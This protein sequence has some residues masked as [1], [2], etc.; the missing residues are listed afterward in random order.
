MWQFFEYLYH[1]SKKCERHQ[2]TTLQI[3]A[4]QCYTA[5]PHQ[6]VAHSVPNYPYRKCIYWLKKTDARWSILFKFWYTRTM[7]T[8]SHAC[9]TEILT[10]AVSCAV[11]RWTIYHSWYRHIFWFIL[12]GTHL[13]LF[14]IYKRLSQR[15]QHEVLHIRVQSAGE[16]NSLPVGV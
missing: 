3:I 6:F 7:C 1:N 11:E 4:F 16:S 8:S 2:N 5:I 14:K 10:M 12:H 15:F 13:Y 9:T